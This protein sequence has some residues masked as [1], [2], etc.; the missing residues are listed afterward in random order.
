MTEEEVHAILLQVTEE[1]LDRMRQNGF[2]WRGDVYGPV[3]LRND[4]IVYDI[5]NGYCDAWAEL[6][7][8]RIPGAF[9]AWIDPDVDHCV[10]VYGGKFYDADCPDGVDRWSQL[11]MFAHPEEE[12]PEP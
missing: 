2:Y 11:P 9:T 12:R 8:Q 1:I 3:R 10:L 7:A 5:N 6:A 4:P